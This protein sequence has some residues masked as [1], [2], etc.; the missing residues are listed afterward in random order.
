V[1]GTRAYKKWQRQ[2]VWYIVSQP[3]YKEPLA[4]IIITLSIYNALYAAVKYTYDMDVHNFL[5]S[6]SSFILLCMDG[7]ICVSADKWI[8]AFFGYFKENDIFWTL[9]TLRF[10]RVP[11]IYHVFFLFH[12]TFSP[13]I[14]PVM[15]L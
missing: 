6:S 8:E 13:F 7:G 4:W 14:F 11:S 15:L 1:Y 9:S 2:K 12:S 3:K 5:Y 10:G